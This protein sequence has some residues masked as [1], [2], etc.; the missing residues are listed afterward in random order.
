MIEILDLPQGVRGVP[1]RSDGEV[2]LVRRAGGGAGLSRLVG[3][4]SYAQHWSLASVW[5]AW[6]QWSSSR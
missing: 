3:G 2:W 6:D 1:R 5:C 4:K